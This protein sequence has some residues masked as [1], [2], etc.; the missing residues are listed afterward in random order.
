MV[1]SKLSRIFKARTE[2]IFGLVAFFVFVSPPCEANFQ[3]VSLNIVPSTGLCQGES[4]ESRIC[5]SSVLTLP[6]LNYLVQYQVDGLETFSFSNCTVEIDSVCKTYL[7]SSTVV[8]N[9]FDEFVFCKSRLIIAGCS[10][11]E[12]FGLEYLQLY[13]GTIR[14]WI[15]R[16]L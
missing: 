3:C 7:I 16:D 4:F 5:T 6:H 9:L 1:I 11:A 12:M 8:F 10:I 2:F 14:S 15:S 13:N